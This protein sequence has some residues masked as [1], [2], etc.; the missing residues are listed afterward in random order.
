[1]K[2]GLLE[3]FGVEVITIDVI[4]DNFEGMYWSAIK[5]INNNLNRDTEN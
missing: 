3:A 4:D 5:K 2:K 1:M